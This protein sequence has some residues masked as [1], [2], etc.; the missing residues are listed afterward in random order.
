MLQHLHASLGVWRRTSLKDSN[1]NKIKVLFSHTRFGGVI[2]GEMITRI[3]TILHELILM[4]IK[5]IQN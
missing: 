3:C 5:S 2:A 1:S 4:K